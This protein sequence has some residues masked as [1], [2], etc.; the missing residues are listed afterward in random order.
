M[1]DL[2]GIHPAMSS[3][4]YHRT[5]PLSF[6]G[7][8]EFM[9]SPAH[10][11][12][13]VDHPEESTAS[14]IKGQLTHCMLLEPKEVE[15]RFIHIK[16]PMNRNPFKAQKEEAE[17]LGLIP[18]GDTTWRDAE[19]MREKLLKHPDVANMIKIGQKETSV[20]APDPTTGVLRKCRPDI[21][22]PA[23]GILGD[24]KYVGDASQDGFLMM[25]RRMKWHI[26][27]AWYLEVVSAA[28]RAPHN[29][30]VHILVEEK[31]PHEVGCWALDDASLERASQT[32]QH[33]LKKF[34][35]CQD[36]NTWPG[37]EP[38]IHTTSIPHYMWA[39]EEE[40]VIA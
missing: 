30:F 2:I 3:E 4:E 34:K 1:S 29:L 12:A 11:R 19:G 21:W 7:F 38:K 5:S 24:L 33:H 31:Y 17:A 22:L 35:H 16:G 8:K 25:L 32:I 40:E 6:T 39:D 20:F 9:R 14:Q 13:Y 10:Y 15:K 27:S 18:V 23:Q 36:T 28:M 26:Q 37:L